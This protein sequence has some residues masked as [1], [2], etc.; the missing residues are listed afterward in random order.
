ME[1]KRIDFIDFARVISALAV[2][3]IHVTANFILEKDTYYFFNQLVRFAVP[4]FF[5]ISGFSLFYSSRNKDRIETIK[6]YKKRFSKIII[7]YIIWTIMYTFYYNRFDIS[8]IN[9]NMILKNLLMGINHLYFVVIIIQFYIIFP[10]L[11]ILYKKYS[12]ITLIISFIISLYFNVALYLPSFGITLVSWDYMKYFYLLFPSWIFFFVVGMYLSDNCDKVMIALKNN[13]SWVYLIT[14]AGFLIILGEGK[15][16]NSYASSLKPSIMLYCT[17]VFLSLMVTFDKIKANAL[18]LWLSK[19]SFGFYLSHMVVFNLLNSYFKV[20][21]F[22][23]WAEVG[24]TYVMTVA[25]T[26]CTVYVI[27]YIPG[28]SALGIVKNKR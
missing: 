11:F 9:T 19:Q 3:C 6:F 27:S 12:K 28:C 20:I 23:G 5:I 24:I 4:L 15:L 22:N 25:C 2:V 18:V 14:F 7:P 17:G 1:K 26:M 8:I 10:L 13:K 16:T 21:Q